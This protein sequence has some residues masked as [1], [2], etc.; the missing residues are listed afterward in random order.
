VRVQVQRHNPAWTER[1]NDLLM[2]SAEVSAQSGRPIP[3]DILIDALQGFPDKGRIVRMLRETGT[4]YDQIA[5]LQQQAQEM[6]KM[7]QAKEAVI[8]SDAQAMGA[9]S[10]ARQMQ[11][12][13]SKPGYSAL[14][15][16]AQTDM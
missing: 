2:R 3:A 16:S 15:Q 9:P 8:R 14:M 5:Q 7:I 12:P 1:F 10:I 4:M 11:N 6:G 13:A